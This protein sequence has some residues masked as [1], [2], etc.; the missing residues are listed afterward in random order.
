MNKDQIT[1]I[2]TIRHYGSLAEI[3]K[4][5]QEIEETLS[6]H[7]YKCIMLQREY[8]VYDDNIELDKGWLYHQDPKVPITDLSGDMLFI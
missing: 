5:Y 3:Y 7:G 8:S 6:R 2:A 1:P 4:Q